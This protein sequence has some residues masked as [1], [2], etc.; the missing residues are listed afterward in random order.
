MEIVIAKKLLQ[1]QKERETLLLRQLATASKRSPN[2]ASASPPPELPPSTQ[3][4]PKKR[5]S[6]ALND[7]NS[8]DLSRSPSAAAAD[9][10]SDDEVPDLPTPPKKK[11]A[12]PKP[13]P[14]EALHSILCAYKAKKIVP[15][16]GNLTYD[17]C[18]DICA[19][20]AHAVTEWSHSQMVTR[21]PM[22][23]SALHLVYKDKKEIWFEERKKTF[24][25][26]AT[27]TAKYWMTV[28]TRRAV[29]WK[30]R[31]K[32]LKRKGSLGVSPQKLVALE[33]RIQA[34]IARRQKAAVFRLNKSG[35]TVT[36]VPNDSSDSDFSSDEENPAAAAAA[37]ATAP[38]TKTSPLLAPGPETYAE[39]EIKN[40]KAMG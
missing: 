4:A 35:K 25:G 21:Q 1:Q 29:I 3:P 36:R 13:Q 37:S 17:I 15:G 33:D 18:A 22:I 23:L 5:K 10:S 34:A 19:K 16:A 7:A 12:T 27:G 24:L 11:L 6:T 38:T 14:Y 39:Y 20:E 28:L 8:I 2:P 9:S 26:S 30:D 31:A 40:F 32:D